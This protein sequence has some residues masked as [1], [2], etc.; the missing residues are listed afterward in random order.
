VWLLDLEGRDPL[1][2]FRC[3]FTSGALGVWALR[4]F[5]CFGSSGASGV[6]GLRH[7]GRFITSGASSLRA[8]REFG[9]FGSSGTSTLQVLRE[10][11]CFSSLR[12]S[13]LRVLWEFE[14]FDTSGIPHTSHFKISKAYLPEHLDQLPYVP[15][16]INDSCSLRAFFSGA[17][18]RTN[19]K[20][21]NA[22][23]PLI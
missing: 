23:E 17:I 3:I 22:Y 2:D 8:L 21:L 1:P 19:F 7:F 5:G 4:H 15:L 6:Q 20:T 11:G 10:F 16:K 13:T 14:H 18:L 12:N 9:H